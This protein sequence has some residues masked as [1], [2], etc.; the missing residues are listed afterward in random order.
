[1]LSLRFERNED[2]PI[3]IGPSYIQFLC[4][5]ARDSLKKIVLTVKHDNVKLKRGTQAFHDSYNIGFHCVS[6]SIGK[7]R[8][9]RRERREERNLKMGVK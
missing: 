4:I 7:K 1:M 2:L 8:V 5:W 3:Y 6:V 9:E